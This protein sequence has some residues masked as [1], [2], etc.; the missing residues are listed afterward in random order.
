LG[1]SLGIDPIPLK[2]CNWNCVYCQLGRTQPL[3]NTR[4]EYVPTCEILAEM[5]QTLAARQPDEI[6]WVTFVGSGEPTLHSGLGW[7]IFQVKGMTGLPVAVITNGALFYLPEV[8]EELA[9]ADAVLPSL[10]AGNTR[11]Y[12]KINRP[13]P[14]LTFDRLV[15]GLAAFRRGFAGKLWVEVMLVN[16]LND[17]EEALNEI[18]SSLQCIQPDQVDINLPTRPPAEAWVQPPG[19]EGLQRAR[20]ILGKIARIVPQPQ[21][22]STFIDS[23]DLA[24]AV[25]G[26]VT[27]H[28]MQEADLLAGLPAYTPNQVKE[29]LARLEDGGQVKKVSRYQTW[30]W[31]AAAAHYAAGDSQLGD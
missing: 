17:N 2:T 13:W 30:F 15:E 16:G 31:S 21:A 12:R 6:D 23:E 28:P 11:L 24:E 18:A 4:Q 27:R 10:D 5:R 26:V 14:K 1:K 25:M 29:V 8:R 22:H 19:E 7:L 20:A 9:A 3:N